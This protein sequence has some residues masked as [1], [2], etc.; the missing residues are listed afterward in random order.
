MTKTGPKRYWRFEWT[1]QFIAVVEGKNADEAWKNFEQNNRRIV[2]SDVTWSQDGLEVCDK[3][4]DEI[5]VD[6]IMKGLKFEVTGTGG[7]CVAYAYP[8][9][10]NKRL[11]VTDDGGLGL[12]EDLDYGD[13]IVGYV[14]DLANAGAKD[15]TVIFKNLNDVI[16][17]IKTKGIR[18][19]SRKVKNSR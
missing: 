5:D 19:L 16:T 11:L 9:S 1:E 8:F 6:A 2:D 10:D 13:V 14:D 18:A 12:P 17:F 15:H 3:D 7:N 4:G